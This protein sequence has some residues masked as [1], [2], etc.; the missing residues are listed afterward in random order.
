[1]ELGVEEIWVGVWHLALGSPV[2][3]NGSQITV[4]FQ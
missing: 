3:I 4:Y 2:E 1:M